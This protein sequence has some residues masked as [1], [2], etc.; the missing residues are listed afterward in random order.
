MCQLGFRFCS[1]KSLIL[2]MFLHLPCGRAQQGLGRR[3]AARSAC[4][5]RQALCYSQQLGINITERV[6]AELFPQSVHIM[7]VNVKMP[8]SEV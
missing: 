6:R 2:E 7:D 3:Q 5:P 1:R 8:P 4:C